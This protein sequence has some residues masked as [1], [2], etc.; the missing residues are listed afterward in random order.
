MFDVEFVCEFKFKLL[1][2]ISTVKSIELNIAMLGVKSAVAERR[3]C[4]SCRMAGLVV[5]CRMKK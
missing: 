1:E 2:L 4:V 3:T 5:N